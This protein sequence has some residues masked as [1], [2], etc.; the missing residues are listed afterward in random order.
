MPVEDPV[1]SGD[2]VRH[3]DAG[4]FIA[5]SFVLDFMVFLLSDLGLTAGTLAPVVPVIKLLPETPAFVL[6]FPAA[7]VLKKRFPESGSPET[8]NYS[9]SP[10][11]KSFQS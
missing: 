3:D 6:S 10:H 4:Y 2:Q 1:F 5:W 7:V 8:H 11:V 9:C